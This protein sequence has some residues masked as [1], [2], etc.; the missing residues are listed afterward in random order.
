M[1]NA[2]TQIAM[3]I[4]GAVALTGLWLLVRLEFLPSSQQYKRPP[5]LAKWAIRPDQFLLYLWTI[6]ISVFLCSLLT[7][8]LVKGMHIQGDLGNVIAGA[9]M[10]PGILIGV[11]A[12]QLY[13]IKEK[14]QPTKPRIPSV[15]TGTATFMIVLP[16]TI[17]V[18][19]LW[20]FFLDQLHFP[21]DQQELV[22][23]FSGN[24]SA[25]VKLLIAFLAVIVAPVSE[26]LIFRA[27]LFRY[28]YGRVPKWLAYLI[29]AVLFAALHLTWNKDT[30]TLE[31]LPAFAPLVVL[32]IIFSIAYERTG[33]I[34]TTIIA[35]A[36]F[37]LNELVMTQLHI[38]GP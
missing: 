22:D 12:S 34:S 38:F 6:V 19:L 15:L 11:V 31:G 30:H 37:N 17:A 32:A 18:T 3:A 26:E 35:H 33:R 24:D 20:G 7:T 36:L 14:F 13:I 29:P 10:H 2:V 28:L 16:I 1:G 23:M 8:W 9:A 5:E 27:G 21:A 4:E 25:A